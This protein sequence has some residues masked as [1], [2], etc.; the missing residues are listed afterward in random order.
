MYVL[1]NIDNQRLEAAQIRERLQVKKCKTYEI[2][3]K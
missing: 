1:K 3:K 2:I